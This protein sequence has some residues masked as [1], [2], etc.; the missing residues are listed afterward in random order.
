MRTKHFPAERR[1]HGARYTFLERGHPG[2]FE[3][4]SELEARVPDLTQ[5]Q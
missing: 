2:R 1:A 4:Y 5:R 3:L